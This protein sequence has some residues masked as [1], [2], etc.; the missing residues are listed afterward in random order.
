MGVS[1]KQLEGHQNKN[2]SFLGKKICFKTTASA[3]AEWQDYRPIP[4]ILGSRLQHSPGKVSSLLA[5]LT[6]L[7]LAFPYLHPSIYLSC[8][9]VYV[10]TY[11][12]TYMCICVYVYICVY[13]CLFVYVYIYVHTYRYVYIYIKGF[14]NLLGKNKFYLILLSI[15]LKFHQ[16]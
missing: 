5:C 14:W 7:E 11:M 12:C 2:W 10:Y 3:P 8:L 15:M 1:S 9:F 4:Q 13:M 6:G 16:E